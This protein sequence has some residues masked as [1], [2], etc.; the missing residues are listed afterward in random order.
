[1]IATGIRYV[2]PADATEMLKKLDP[3]QRPANKDHVRRLAADMTDGR[4]GLSPDPVVVLKNGNLANGQHR[5]MAVVQS[6]TTQALMVSSGWDEDVYPIMDAGLRRTLALRVDAPWLKMKNALAMVRSAMGGVSVWRGV[7][8]SEQQVVAFAMDHEETFERVI[9]MTHAMKMRAPVLGACARAML[10]GVDAEAVQRF[11]RVATTGVSDGP[12][13]SAAV[14]LFVFLN[15]RTRIVGGSTASI[16]Y[17]KAQAALFNF[18][19]GREVTHIKGVENEIWV[20][21][22][23]S[24]AAPVSMRRVKKADG[25]AER[26]R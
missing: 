14:R 24:P 26:A 21:P 25:P 12:H 8:S 22:S 20:L 1:M 2:S 16:L 6:G 10:H 4:F 17:M 13:E 18:I 23:D 7:K 3:R 9:R 15:E 19:Q 5:L 11:L